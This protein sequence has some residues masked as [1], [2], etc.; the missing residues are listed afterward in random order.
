[1]GR[2]RFMSKRFIAML[3]VTFIVFISSSIVLLNKKIEE[4]IIIPIGTQVLLKGEESFI[5]LSYVANRN[6][7]IEISYIHVGD[8]QLVP[9]EKP[10]HF[11]INTETEERD[12]LIQSY[13]YYNLH[14]VEFKVNESE[15]STLTAATNKN[16]TAFFSNGVIKEFPLKVEVLTNNKEYLFIGVQTRKTADGESNTIFTIT[17]AVTI[18]EM[19]TL[20]PLANIKLFKEDK[21]LTLPYNTEKGETLTI[22]ISPNYQIWNS[23]YQQAILRGKFANGETFT[24]EIKFYIA[25]TPSNKWIKDF[26]R[27]ERDN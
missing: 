16:S 10:Y 14:S 13:P 26:V 12:S 8:L 21:Q 22:R 19:E 11:S 23:K 9:Y 24:E 5:R 18:E 20:F 15:Y 6:E 3:A 7:D 27:E 2:D 25:D 17:E 1:M 4:P